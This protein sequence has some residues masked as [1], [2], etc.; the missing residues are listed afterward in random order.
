MSQLNLDMLYENI[1]FNWIH[2]EIQDIS[3]IVTYYM[4][5]EMIQEDL[6]E[7]KVNYKCGG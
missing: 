7:Y 4:N 2:M 5:L 1:G 6:I 3:W